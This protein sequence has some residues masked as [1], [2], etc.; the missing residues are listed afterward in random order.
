MSIHRHASLNRAFSLVWS[1]KFQ[2][3]VPAP[4]RTRA[5][6]KRGATTLAATVLATLIGSA[7]AADPGLPSGGQVTTGSAS[8]QQSGAVMTIRQDTQAAAIDWQRFSIGAGNTVHFVQP[9]SA[10]VALNRVLGQD[11]T[12]IYGTLQANGQVFLVNPNGILF[13]KGAQVST[14]G[15]LATTRDISTTDFAN[16]KFSFSGNGTGTVVN[17]GSLRAAQGG[18]VALIGAQVINS[19]SIQAPGGD[20]R[21][22]AADAVSV[23]LNGAGLAGFSVDRGTLNA[24][25]ANHGL[26][27]APGGRVALTADAADAVARA[28][29]NH[30]GIIE[31]QGVD[32]SNGVV[33]LRGDARTGE[34]NVSGR[35]DVSS[36]GGQGGAVA[37]S[38]HAVHLQAGAAVD[39]SG[40]TGGGKVRIGGGWQ[41]Q[42]ADI[43]NAS[44]VTMAPGASIDV[45][46]RQ[47]GSGGT[48]VLW[49]Q[50]YTAFGG[51]I[52]ARGGAGGG[53]G[54]KVETSSKDVLQAVGSVDTTAPAG[55]GGAWLLDPRN[56]TIASSG[57]SGTAYSAN[58][59]PAADSVILASSINASLNAGTS[60]TITTGTTGTSAG[61]I[62]VAAPIT[63]NNTA[64]YVG[65]TLTL[66]AANNINV[67]AAIANTTDSAYYGNRLNVVLT[68]GATGNVNFGATGS[69][70][71]RGGNVYVGALSGTGGSETVTA[72]GNN[73]TMAAGSFIQTNG[74]ML[75]ARV[76]GTISL[77]AGSLRSSG[78]YSPYYTTTPT[79]FS[80]RGIAINLAAGTITSTNTDPTVADIRTQV[81]TTLQAGTIGSSANPI[82][83]GTDTAGDAYQTLTVNNTTGSSYVS[84]M[85]SNQVFSTVAVNVSSQ[86][87]STQD[88]R[89]MGDFGGTGHDG[90]GHLLLRNDAN[91]VL[92]VATD[93]VNTVGAGGRA[94]SV[95]LS[96]PSMSF[97]DNAVK[98]GDGYFSASGTTLA[99]AAAGNGVADILSGD[100]RLNARDVGTQARPLELATTMGYTDSSLMVTNSGGSTFLKIVD[101]SFNYVKLMNVK[102]VGT[103][104][105]LYAGG[106]RIV[107]ASDGNNVVLPTISGGPT[108]GSTFFA[109]NGIDTTRTT[110]KP[111]YLEMTAS[112][113]GFVLGDNAVNLGAGSFSLVIPIYNATGIIA[114]ANSY[115]A[116]APVAQITA[117]DVSFSVQNYPTPAAS[118]IGAGGKDIQIAQ[119]AGTGNNTLSVGTQQGNV[120]IHE[121]SQNHF[122]TISLS[123]G[124]ASAAQNVAIDLA[125]PDDINFSDSGSLVSVDATKVNVAANNRNF[126]LTAGQRSIQT[127]GNSLG[128][129]SYTLSAGGSASPSSLLKLNG[130]IRTIGGDITLYG[131]AG[132]DL[133]K[134]VLVDSNVG[135]TGIGGTIYLYG[136]YSNATSSVSSSGGSYSLTV[137]SSSTAAQGGYIYAPSNVDNRAGN[138]LSGL[139]FNATGAT[140]A[141]DNTVSLASRSSGASSILLKGDFS[142]A[143]NTYLGNGN[144]V[145]IDTEQ[146]NTASAGNIS[147]SGASLRS[148]TS[149]STGQT[150]FN[151]STNFLTGNGGNV[152][153]LAQ[154]SASNPLSLASLLVD[155]R[156][157]NGTSGDIS[158]SAVSTSANYGGTGS[159][160]YYGRNITLYGDLYADAR[161]I[162]LNGDVRLTRSVRMN[163]IGSL[164]SGAGGVTL[165]AVSAT[166]T[167][168]GLT[169]TT[170]V[171]NASGAVVLN[172][173]AGMAGGYYLDSLSINTRG[174]IASGISLNAAVATEGSQTYAA[175]ALTATGGLS[176]NGGD[177]DLSGMAGNMQTRGSTYTITTD[178]A[179]GT[180]A[181]GRLLLGNIALNANSAGAVAL[182][183]DT[184]ADGGGANAALTLNGVGGTTSYGAINVAAGSVT[185]NGAMRASSNAITVEARGS[186]A[187]LTIASTG[188]V[189]TTTAGN[190]VLAAG[191]NFINN[192][193]STGISAAGRYFVYSTDPAAST[194]GMTG[195]SKHYNQAYV[196]GA[197]PSYAGSG[198][199]F[200]YSVA[201]VIS[202]TPSTT[203]M[204]YGSAEP[205]T[206][207][208]ASNYS[209]MIDG[210]TLSS[211]TGSQSFTLA[212]AGTLSS[213]GFRQVGSYAYTL[214]G[215]LTDSLGYQYAPF[216]QSLTVTP[217]ALN[218][219]G[220]S[221]NNKTYDGSAAATLSGTATATALAGDL[222]AISGTGTGAFA[223]ANAG[224][225][226]AVAVSG[227]TATGT[228]AGNYQL[229][230]PSGLTA[231]ITPRT[232]TVT[233]SGIAT[234]TYDG[235]ATA[236]V[237]VGTVTGFVGSEMV[238]VS[239]SGNF[240]DKNVGT[241]KAVSASYSLADGNNGGRAANYVLAG[242]SLSG[243]ITAKTITVAATGVN[244]VYDGT[245]AA[246]ATLGSS[247]VVGGDVVNFSG[248]ASLADKNVGTGKTVSVVGI[249]ASGADAG[250]YQLA[251]TTASGTLDVTAKTITVAATGVNKV[252]DGTTAATANLA[253]SGVVNGDVVNFSG[254]ASFGNKNVGSAKTVSVAGIGASGADAANY[255][256][257]A[258]TATTAANVTAKAI[259]VD[260]TGV[261][262][263]YDGTTAAS[264]T[265]A[266]SGVI[267]GDT[268]NF[269][270]TASFANKNAGTAK[271][272]NVAGISASGTDAGNYTLTATTAATTADIAA[273]AITVAATGVNKVYDGTT[274]ASASLASSGVVSGDAVS[275][276]GT[277]TLAD[278]NVGT[279]K[280]VSVAGISASGVDAGN[281]AIN[282]TASTT[283]NVTAKAITVAATGVNKVYDGTTSASANLASSG[284]VSG[285]VVNFSGTATLANKNVGTGKAVSVAGIAASGADAGNY[286]INTTA[287]TTAN[288]TAKAITVAA[289]GV[290]KV[291]D[292]STA[293]TANLASSGVV[294]GDVV[295][296]SGTATLADK[297]VGTGKTVSVAGIAASGTDAANYSINTT[298]GTTANVTAKTI[299]VAAAGVNKV[300]DG[301]TAASA[302]LSSSGVVNGD[303]VNFSGTASFADKNVGT[304][305]AVTVA[306]IGASGTDAG[307]YLLSG[308]TATTA[309]NVTAKAIT[310]AAAGTNKVY[311]GTTAAAATL[312]SSGVVAGDTVN[313][314]GTASFANKNVGTGK[315]VSVAGIS[316]SGADAANYALTGTTASTT[317]DVT[318]KAITVAAT[319]V[320]KV[321]DGSTSASAN[322]ASS[323][324]VSGDAVNF[325]G[326]A[327]LADKN[328]GTGK[329]VSVA[330]IAASGADAGNYSINT[331][332]STTANVT[333]KAITVAAT[334]VNKVYDGTTAA[335]ANLASSGVVAGDV[336]NFSGTATLANKNVGTGKAV[337]VAGIAAS[338]TDAGN[339]S[340]NTTASTTANVTAKAITVAATGV[341]KVYD[342]TTAAGAN[343]ASSGVVSGDVVSFTGTATLADKNVG[344]G[345]T[346]SVAGI[347]ASGTDAGNYSINTTASTTADVTAKAITVAA[348]GVNK[349]YDGT[350]A[351]SANLASSGVVAGD[352]VS[353]TGT[354]TLADKN[355][356]TGKTVSVAGISAS[357]IDAGNYAINTTASTTA[358][359]TAKA[360]T[361]AAAGVNKVYDGT[362]AANATLSSSGVLAGD[363]V[364][365]GGNATFANKNA[366][367]GKTVSVA[368]ISAS[369]SDAANYALTATTATTTADI[370]TKAITVAATGVNK[371]YDGSTAATANLASNG[372][373]SGDVVNFTGT[374]TLADKNVGTGKAVSV[375]GISA[376]GTDAANYAINTTASTTA[377]VTAKAI[378]VAAT[379]VNKVYDGATSATANLASNG[380]VAGDLVNFTGTATLADKNVGTGKTVSVAGISASGTDAA[381]YAINTTASTTANVTAKAITVAAT[382][383]NKVY[384]G[385]TAAAANLASSGVVSGDVVNFTG[386]ATL[387]D[388]NVGAG[389][390]VSV[391]GISAS[392]VDAGNYAINTT[393]STTANVTAKAITVAATGVNKVYD[394]T[395]AASANLASSGVV[396]GDAVSFTGTA[397]LADKNVG[398]GKTVSVAGISAS[399]VDAGNYAIN[400]TASTTANVTAK[401]ITVAAAGVNKVYDGSTAANATLSSSGVLAGDTVNFG[402]TATFA[403]KNVG[404][405]KAVSVVGIGASGADAGNYVLTGTTASTTADVAAK[406]IAVAAT[407]VNKVYDG[408]TAA[409]ANLASNGV[410]AGDV[411]NFN[412]T[413]TLADKNVGTGKAVSVAG[414]T[415]SGTDAG[416]Y[417][418]NTTATTSADVAAKAITVAAAGVNK[419]YDGSTSATANLASNGV[420]AGDAVSFS[421]TA[422]LADKNVGTGKT[423]SVAGI[424]A[425]GTDAGN[426]TFNTTA[427]TTADV[428]AKAI[429]V[430]ATGVNKVYDGATAATTNLT[431]SGVVAGD[432]VSFTGTATLVDK[433]VG[434]GKTVSVAGIRASG[435]DAGNY[436]INT[437]ASTTA[438]VTAKS[439][440]VAATGVNKVYDG[441]TSATANLASNGIVAG[442][443]V[444]FTGTAT[445]ADKNVGT[446]K[447]VS[448]AGIRASG[449]DAGNY[450]IN[451]TASTTADVTA[452]AITV[453][454]TGVNKVYDGATSATANL[455]SNGIVA[456]DVVNFTGTATLAD[457]NVGTGKTVSVAGITASGSDAGNYAINTSATTKADVLA[458]SITVAATGVGKVY[459]GTAAAS[460]NLAS[461]G[462]VAGD[463]VSFTGNA[464][465]ADKNAGLGKA[466]GVTGIAA[467]GA[468]ARNYVL[469]ATTAATTAD[470]AAKAITVA[471]T[472][473]NKVYD[474]S[475]AATADLASNG[476]VAGDVVS[477]NG[478]AT[479]ADKNVG[480]GKTVSVAGIT[481]SGADAGNY[482]INTTASTTADVAAKAITVA[483][484]G[485]GKVYDGST[486]ATADLASNGVVAG[487]VVS[488]TGTATLADKNVGTGKTVSVAGIRASGADAGNYAINTTAATTAD[489]TAKSITVA[490]TGVNKVYDGSTDASVALASGGVVAG[491]SLSFSGT[492]RFADKNAAAGKAVS[493]TGIA[494]SG[495]DAGNYRLSSTTATTS[496]DVA[497]KTIAVAAAGV[498][499]VY[500]GSTAV[501]VRLSPSGV[502]AGDSVAATGNAVLADRDAGTGKAVTV[503][504]ITLLGADA[505][506]YRTAGNATT[507]ADVNPRPLLVALQGTVAKAQDGG[508]AASLDSSNY[509]IGN[510]VLGDFIRVVQPQGRYADASTGTGKAVYATL[511]AGDY[512]ADG[513][514]RLANY[515]LY[516]GE[517]VGAVGTVQDATTTTPS[518]ASAVNSAYTAASVP[519]PGIESQ[520]SQG[521]DEGG[522]R[523]GTAQ[524]RQAT[525]VSTNTAENLLQ[526]RTFSVADGGIRLPAGV[527]GSDRDAPQ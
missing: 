102:D 34:V 163:T 162:S 126:S 218:V 509:A 25:V 183:I 301:T 352:V 409:S 210:D 29:V 454:A 408:S 247:G 243:D 414:I 87:N 69:I 98:T 505:A 114:A 130:D 347:A 257:S 240:A 410:V 191:R 131:Y 213:A 344:T 84:Q 388:K 273:K 360:I 442:D 362:T 493:V 319:G 391:A 411:V 384:D 304:A 297:N 190:V 337:S 351:A 523:Q 217:R 144:G 214:N 46:A 199:W 346:V 503:T 158:L 256:L 487:D 207:L 311:D 369:G 359:V 521:S 443:G 405:G 135:R 28:V 107:Y 17:E 348:T 226:K 515:R 277:A 371:V 445:L 21:L 143:G 110:S 354:A 235:N 78:S 118:T 431:S 260:A 64:S 26:I 112:S 350:T 399:G 56:V 156:S 435:A 234:K 392:G 19:G 1:D 39:A 128:T 364:N 176:T 420:V 315:A 2:A 496:A 265:L 416:N 209:G 278:K 507:T 167:G 124:S 290:N 248:T 502:V 236:T 178:R 331:T 455:A 250:N 272:V 444:S 322:L 252:Y 182:T 61:D 385:S 258:T 497:A 38:G 292:G 18:Y 328:V 287:S 434:T 160:S 418:I 464:S 383:V 476:I 324:V 470:I 95:E 495:A 423:V 467:A 522:N 82:K 441:S 127:D 469:A 268:V 149:Y 164:G 333:A 232:L 266:S 488:F 73:L 336:V 524:A 168:A 249:G 402:G 37:V 100:I 80:Q 57:A 245:T 456:G 339:Y 70:T 511:S 171:G 403:N 139:S 460:A 96:A 230:Q 429:T 212:P 474:G 437:T 75:D 453:A 452:K 283:A 187:D 113:G 237:N 142:S 475:T 439:I 68:P 377:D 295:N 300:Y 146:G 180:N 169:I 7:S 280:A 134:S 367:T 289:T 517:V 424:N 466:I 186:A 395:T 14:A 192:K 325:T 269:G 228:D 22:A 42:D 86:A 461:S 251:G 15:L 31:A 231:T 518:Y 62:T 426:Y 513:T 286:S 400:T 472:G 241:A 381:N 201:P 412:G 119:G 407:G 318:A 195:Y 188:S 123:L 425:S 514:T 202:V 477:F 193:G 197:T 9:S 302:S 255:V 274:N 133:L 172:G 527:R 244:K 490:A 525:V 492:A 458:K 298:A 184:T 387:A 263:T 204:V 79:A 285:D 483:A 43:A 48:A 140:T 23:R 321:Y 308:T 479:L 500:D 66:Q 238:V 58:Y 451:T 198:N 349:V 223:N 111:R 462:V 510:L 52:A 271:A 380:I 393:A 356:G 406:A 481:A 436:A 51:S 365:F 174:S 136:D 91:G 340:I 306:G 185:L 49:S 157:P 253:S 484:T 211:F 83:I 92:A 47:Q 36:A 120:A 373:V 421:G 115:N 526:R 494:A 225:N 233:G 76:N 334:G 303:V 224:V 358:N 71:T 491:D 296:F 309:A 480:T 116:S 194:E 215:T 440:T 415:A 397:T 138:Y 417:T 499:K 284:V 97:A 386:T 335:S 155:T 132:V 93:D 259:T 153:L 370:A 32:S 299:T 366:G 363:T 81:S 196:A 148:G 44:T 312:S 121:L 4:E 150:Y 261:N 154:N 317:A 485:V 506:N 109:T 275:F 89:L 374:A 459:D 181:A 468:D 206:T 6:G 229:V 11:P 465:F 165:G 122:K 220:I 173:G 246:T 166:T 294:S 361:V 267:A 175:G 398:T 59:V 222:V 345:K 10:A 221:A 357:G 478:T 12:Q 375:A 447:T 129:G 40:A 486:A 239:A 3:W 35:V 20:V 74:G 520:V 305:K 200:L 106:D 203:T 159:Q 338:G 276:T 382:G 516:T 471:A 16:G 45:S 482:A 327:T 508:T 310:V 433:N 189:T 512:R 54:G 177:I 41:G 368:G 316:A 330:G 432:T 498:D 428:T 463:S 262:K 227:Y 152:S 216:A 313:F 379:G 326:T 446:G 254:T 427:S 53:D 342:G 108:D 72:Q 449:T 63:V 332:A 147:F 50:D 5:R 65:P 281:Y 125:G 88:I 401:A 55:K 448:V 343:L 394:G 323:G 291:Y 117:G 396:S 457:K 105:I 501:A 288:V 355:V 430:A 390:A 205:A 145:T 320:N 376:S 353:F 372:V 151:A 67:N 94:T 438:D 85:G 103:H 104:H 378:T 329:A 77:A 90:T 419:V 307:N 170:G 279:G 473:V 137:D 242:Q 8:I 208:G 60:V 219:S 264:A 24:L 314:G 293:A 413:A 13:G 30:T 341:N 270:G 161:S 101:D 282:T 404:T 504:G 450:A 519:T 33:E 141:S 389:K 489:V 422:T 27:Q 99:S 179:G